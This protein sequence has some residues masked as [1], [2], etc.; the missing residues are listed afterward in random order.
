M[1]ASP[2]TVRL[3]DLDTTMNVPADLPSDR[4]VVPPTAEFTVAW[5]TYGCYYLGVLLWWP[6]IVGLIISYVRRDQPEAGFIRSHYHWLIRT[7]WWSTL[8]WIT[9]IVLIIGG[10]GP[11]V[12]DVLRSARKS[13]GEWEVDALVQIDWSSIFA[14]AG[15]ATV[16][17]IGVLCVYLWLLYR[18]LRGSLRLA[19][20][21]PAP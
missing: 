16:G 10:V 4:E 13:G 18:L 2:A 9:S 8:A 20:A 7:F 19:N 5:V 12:R 3:A 6:S 15:L 1:R 14:A 21:R 17:G 11:I